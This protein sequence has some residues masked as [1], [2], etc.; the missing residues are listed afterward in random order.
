MPG[1]V[2][3]PRGQPPTPKTP[4]PPRGEGW[5]IAKATQLLTYFPNPCGGKG[6]EGGVSTFPDGDNGGRPSGGGL[7][8]G[9]MVTTGAAWKD[10]GPAE[11][12]GPEGVGPSRGCRREKVGRALAGKPGT[13]GDHRDGA[14]RS[15]AG[16]RR[17][18]EASMSQSR[19]RVPFGHRG[20]KAKRGKI[21]AGAE[22]RGMGRAVR[23]ASQNPVGA[24]AAL[25]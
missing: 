10:R 20:W 3:S 24:A 5:G 1:T 4:P 23:T 9:A 6:W 11:G 13:R 17:A 12:K 25:G 19:R 7:G 22:A 18:V 8:L 2:S 15:R 14:S 21:S 16:K